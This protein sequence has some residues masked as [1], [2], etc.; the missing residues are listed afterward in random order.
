MA[1]IEQ[2]AAQVTSR[3]ELPPAARRCPCWSARR[4]PLARAYLNSEFQTLVKPEDVARGEVF[5][6]ST[7]YW[8]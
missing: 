3:Q 6:N 1:S 2:P 8:I 7:C 4:S 5:F